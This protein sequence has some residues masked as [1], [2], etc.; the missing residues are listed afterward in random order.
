ME[1]KNK[2]ENKIEDKNVTGVFD[3]FRNKED[4]KDIISNFIA[5][6]IPEDYSG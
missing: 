4:Y 6:T 1:V 5:E 3:N 2:I